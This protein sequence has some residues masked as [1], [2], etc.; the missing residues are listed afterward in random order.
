MEHGRHRHLTCLG[1]LCTDPLGAKTLGL[2]HWLGAIK[3]IRPVDLV[4]SEHNFIQ[5]VHLVKHFGP[6]CGRVPAKP[7]LVHGTRCWSTEKIWRRLVTWH[8]VDDALA[9]ARRGVVPASN[10][11]GATPA[12]ADDEH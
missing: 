4:G 9:S 11:H 8:G 1:K 6:P 7:G 10:P 3:E 12:T 5:D 2:D